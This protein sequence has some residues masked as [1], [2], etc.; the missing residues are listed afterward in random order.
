MG[1]LPLTLKGMMRSAVPRA[2]GGTWGSRRG[3]R[4][5]GEAGNRP[6]GQ[7]VLCPGRVGQVWRP[8][9]QG[10]FH[11]HK[12]CF[13]EAAR[14]TGQESRQGWVLWA[15]LAVGAGQGLSQGPA[16]HRL[17]GALPLCAT[18]ATS[19]RLPGLLPPPAG[20]EVKRGLVPNQA[21]ASVFSY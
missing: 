9:T 11:S 3:A 20:P 6:G 14:P 2:R 16:W 5:R 19:P 4:R 13:E 1:P 15:V 10:R 7:A 12:G 18:D 8:T 21:G 17:G